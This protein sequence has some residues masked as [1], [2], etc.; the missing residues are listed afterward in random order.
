MVPVRSC[1]R[2]LRELF[3]F[4]AEAFLVASWSSLH[5][6]LL[7]GSCTADAED[8]LMA[9]GFATHCSTEVI[10]VGA[11]FS[12]EPPDN[13]TGVIENDFAAAVESSDSFSSEDSYGRC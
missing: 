8:K 11:D 6:V 4:D 2:P 10:I 13:Y 5:S 1:S 9:F 7:F 12:F 3:D